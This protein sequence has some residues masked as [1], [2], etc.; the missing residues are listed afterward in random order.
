M[1]STVQY[2]APL[3]HGLYSTCDPGVVKIGEYY[4][5]VFTSDRFGGIA[6]N[7]CCSFQRS[8]DR[9]TNGMVRAGK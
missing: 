9:T 8:E 1:R 5:L 2:K 6:N 4:Y 7:V 3:T